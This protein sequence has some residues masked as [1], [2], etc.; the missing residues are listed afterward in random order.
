MLA[1]SG[2][3]TSV[4]P[5]VLELL[6]STFRD[7]RGAPEGTSTTGPAAAL[8]IPVRATVAIGDGAND[9]PMIEVAGLGIAYHAKPKTEAAADA[10]VRYGNL[11][12]VRYALGLA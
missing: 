4:P 11:D 9:I 1:R 10:R 12:V 3:P 6:V 2:I 5:Q 8:G 7:L